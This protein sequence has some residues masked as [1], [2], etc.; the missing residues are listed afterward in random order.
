M[1]ASH[2]TPIIIPIKDIVQWRNVAQ[3]LVDV[4]AQC[5]PDSAVR[6]R[7]LVDNPC[8]PYGFPEADKPAA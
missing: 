8:M 6:N 5:V 1:L 7:I 2:S 4:L 3:S